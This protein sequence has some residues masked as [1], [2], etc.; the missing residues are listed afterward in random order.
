MSGASG[1]IARLLRS[2]LFLEADGR[3]LAHGRAEPIRPNV[4]TRGSPNVLEDEMAIYRVRY[5]SEVT[6]GSG[7][8]I[9]IPQEMREDMNLDD[10]DTLNARLEKSESG[11]M[12]IT[13]TKGSG[14]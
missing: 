12:Q 9:T 2:I 4:T 1:Y 10:G 7:G 11:K 13:L 8:R 5:Y 6:V 3:P 14:G